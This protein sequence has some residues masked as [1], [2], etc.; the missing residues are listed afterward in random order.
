MKVLIPIISK[1]ESEEDFLDMALH[2]AKEVILLLVVD[3]EAM[4]GEFGFAATE[5]MH[6]N[7]LM[8]E[9]KRIALEKR[10]ACNDI[11]EWGNT[12]P[13]IINTAKLYKVD[14]VVIKKQKNRLFRSLEKELEKERIKTIIL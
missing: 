9:I 4:P 6:G 11:I 10:K 7:S 1:Q 8:G 13:K 14:K 3:T 12:I 2:K 5:I